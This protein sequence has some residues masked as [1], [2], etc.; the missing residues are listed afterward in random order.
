MPTSPGLPPDLRGALD[1]LA[2][3]MSRNV[4]AARAAAQSATYRAGG[5]SQGIATVADALAYAFIRLPAT[6]AAAVAVLDA[7]R[8]VSPGFAPRTMLDVGAGPGTAAFAATRVFADIDDISLIDANAT[9]RDLALML[10][11]EADSAPLRQAVD[12]RRYRHGDALALVDG[13]APADLVVASYSA[14]EMPPRELARFAT[15]LWSATAGALAVIEPGTPAGY[16]RIMEMRTALVAAGARVAAP[17]PHDRACPL[18]APDWCHF[19]R[20]LPR[21][22]DHLRVKGAAVPF[23]DEKFS[24]VVLTRSAPRRI[25]ARVLAPPKTAKSA[26]TAK[27]CTGDGLVVEVAGR[28]DAD[29]YRRRRSWRWGD[30]V[31]R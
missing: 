11:A 7:L 21:S 30:E 29:A 17:C 9:L 25:D 22:R 18:A 2:Y 28:R 20:R 19:A 23:E 10:M 15:A 16:A 12:G 31:A 1:K 4:I 13:A 6:Y 3:G 26:I 27:L 24:Y 8:E 5:G 14:G